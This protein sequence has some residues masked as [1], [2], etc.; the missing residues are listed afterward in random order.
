M[1]RRQ[2]EIPA[3]GPDRFTG[4]LVRVVTVLALT[5][6]AWAQT[7]S[8]SRI[9]GVVHDPSNLGV[10]GVQV[11]VT[12]TATEAVRTVT[13][14]AD[15]TYTI[16]NLTVGSYRLT[17]SKTGFN[18][19]VQSGIILQVDVNPLINIPLSL[20]QV[21]QSVFVDAGASMVETQSTG[22][23]QVIDQRAIVDLPLNGRQASQLVTL[24]GA[25]VSTF[26]G[27]NADTRHYPSDSSFSVAGGS[28]TATNFLLDGGAA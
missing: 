10:E 26:N 7:T 3:N 5:I 22:V 17:A 18:T 27:A 12:N 11:S 16:P 4:R 19:Y 28:R 23:G 20:G 1:F 24:A 6:G 8:T 15:G 13:T 25:A 21:S 14:E 2:R 9:A